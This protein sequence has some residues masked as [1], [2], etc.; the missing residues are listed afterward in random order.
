MLFS[1]LS[2]HCSYIKDAVI[3]D[4]A[5]SPHSINADLY[6]SKNQNLIIEAGAEL[7]IADSVNIVV[8]GNLFIN[9]T[10]AEPVIIKG[11]TEQPGWGQIQMLKSAKELTITYTTI[12]DGT[13]LSYRTENYLSNVH[14]INKQDL[15]WRWALARFELG[16]LLIEHC[17]ANGV[18][19]AEGFLVH[20]IDDPIVRNCIF[21]NIPDAVEFINCRNGII[22]NN[23]FK[24]GGDD[25][26]DLN[27]CIDTRI[28]YNNIDGYNSAGMEIGSEQLGRSINVK[29]L[30][31]KIRNC[32]MGV[33]L[34][35]ASS[36]EMTRDS[37]IGNN[38][39]IHISTPSDSLDLS[40]AI[41]NKCHFSENQEK[42][43]IDD[44]SIIE[45]N[46]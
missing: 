39:A 5:N 27:G 9:G 21:T 42:I 22:T 20:I 31:N 16:D 24:G 43:N 26:I 33:Y 12:Q 37:L 46:E 2:T 25:A 15:N 11:V 23:T 35:E 38:I 41:L 17:L 6:I 44:R 36:V 19:K 28:E 7:I 34:K 1:L 30:K 29:T 18:N 45:V 40:Q 13:I 4:K 32:K 3:F 8:N 10:E 14:F